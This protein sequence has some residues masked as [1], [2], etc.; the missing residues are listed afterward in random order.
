MCDSRGEPWREYLHA[1][2]DKKVGEES[3]E[4]HIPRL[5]LYI[6]ELTNPYQ[7]CACKKCKDPDFVQKAHRYASWNSIN[8]EKLDDL[9]DDQYFLCSRLVYGYVLR[10]RKWRML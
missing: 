4:V 9:T 2:T 5:G 1:R 8:Q 6:N 10:E 3:M 7:Q